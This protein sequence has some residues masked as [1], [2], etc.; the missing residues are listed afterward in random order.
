MSRGR[1]AGQ[2][3]GDPRELLIAQPVGGQGVAAL[4]GEGFDPGLVF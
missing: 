3:A 2:G 4:V 1:A